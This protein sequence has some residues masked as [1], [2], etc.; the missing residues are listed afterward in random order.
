MNKSYLLDNARPEA[1]TRFEAISAL[2]DRWTFA[3]IEALGI[4]SGWR[5]W[6]VGAGGV[7]VPAW[8][9]TRVAPAGQVLATDID[10]VW[11]EGAISGGVDVRRHDVAKDPPPWTDL[12]LVHARPVLVHGMS[13]DIAP[14]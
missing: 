1:G 3:Q 5:C 11:A 2:F 8:L 6:E 7:N 12:D 14:K 4:A 13:C 9:A 10:I